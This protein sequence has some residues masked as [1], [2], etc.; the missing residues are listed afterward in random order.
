MM[1]F[2]M[3]SPFGEAVDNCTGCMEC[4]PE[5]GYSS[6]ED[7]LRCRRCRVQME[8]TAQVGTPSPNRFGNRRPS[9]GRRGGNFLFSFLLGR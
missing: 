9:E 3:F 5:G 1:L 8:I 7:A 4:V 6:V 2:Q